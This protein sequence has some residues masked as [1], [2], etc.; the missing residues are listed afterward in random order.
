MRSG[1]FWFP[2]LFVLIYIH[3]CIRC[4]L[5]I[6]G[7]EKNMASKVISR[8][9]TSARRGTSSKRKNDNQGGKKQEQSEQ[10]RARLLHAAKKIFARDGFEGAKLEEIAAAA[11]YTRGAFYANFDSKEGLFMAML[12]EK[13]HERIQGMRKAADQFDD[14]KQKLEAVR[15]HFANGAQD[16][17]WALIG[18]EFK[19]FAMRHRELKAKVSAMRQRIFATATG[20]LEELFRSSKAKLPVSVMAF[21][22]SIGALT[23]G[24]ELDRLL[25][26]AISE[27]EIQKVFKLFFD[28]MVQSK[29]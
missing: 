13:I 22:I 11:G 27:E 15:D 20:V 2:D 26:K 21:V 5:L 29:A 18:L 1:K 7:C 4:N 8:A 24:L 12:E 3:V 9:K 10:T 16:C 17:E 23:H 6:A 25:D 14:P 19:L 28:C